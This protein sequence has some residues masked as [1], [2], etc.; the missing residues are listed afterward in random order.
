MAGD[1]RLY[2]EPL[3]Q[4]ETVLNP[5]ETTWCQLLLLA[6]PVIVVS[7]VSLQVMTGG[8]KKLFFGPLI[9]PNKDNMAMA[10][11][12]TRISL[13]CGEVNNFKIVISPFTVSQT[14]SGSEWS[15]CLSHFTAKKHTT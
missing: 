14:E 10:V 6:R 12:K 9:D 5:G 8:I 15:R 13:L 1:G 11:G 2:R 7:A 3:A 4:V